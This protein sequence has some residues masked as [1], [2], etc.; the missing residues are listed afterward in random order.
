[1]IT[2]QDLEEA[3][4]E[5]KGKK[6]PN[7]NTCIMLA[8]FLIIQRYLYGDNAE[9]ENSGYSFSAPPVQDADNVVNYESDT[10][11]G[12]AV[13]GKDAYDMWALMDETM[14]TLQVLNPPLYRSIMRRI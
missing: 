10:D 9:A 5:C 13:Y 6:N 12:Q 11:F 8:S 2:K 14:T 1:M 7:A 3:I 4:A